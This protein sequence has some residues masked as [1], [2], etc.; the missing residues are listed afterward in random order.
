MLLLRI[1]AH[2]NRI[3]EVQYVSNVEN[4]DRWNAIFFLALLHLVL[5]LQIHA[6]L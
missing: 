5:K 3:I 1:A 4:I 2:N 6:A